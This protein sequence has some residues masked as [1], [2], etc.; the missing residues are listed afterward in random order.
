MFLLQQALDTSPKLA[1][2]FNRCLKGEI[3]PMRLMFNPQIDI[4]YS[5]SRI[6]RIYQDL[7][8]TLDVDPEMRRHVIRTLNHHQLGVSLSYV[9]QEGYGDP[10]PFTSI[11][12]MHDVK[13]LEPLRASAPQVFAA[14]NRQATISEAGKYYL[15]EDIRGHSDEGGS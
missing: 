5:R 4:D 14:I 12:V 3:R 6:P 9:E 2:A 8:R 1:E 11:S 15:L 7:F 10:R 13:A